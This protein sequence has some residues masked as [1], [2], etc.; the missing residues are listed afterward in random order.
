MCMYFS[1]L[2]L[3]SILQKCSEPAS[4]LLS[5]ALYGL[6][7]R[8]R[9]SA[10]IGLLHAIESI[11]SCRDLRDIKGIFQKNVISTGLDQRLSVLRAELLHHYELKKCTEIIAQSLEVLLVLVGKLPSSEPVPR[12]R[13][14]NFSSK[15][16]ATPTANSVKVRI[17]PSVWRKQYADWSGATS[18][19]LESR[20]DCIQ[21]L[22]CCIPRELH[23]EMRRKVVLEFLALT[24]PHYDGLLHE[25]QESGLRRP[26][27]AGCDASQYLNA[28]LSDCFLVRGQRIQQV[29]PQYAL[30]C[31]KMG[32]IHQEA[33]L[34]TAS[35]KLQMPLDVNIA[36]NL[37]GWLKLCENKSGS[38]PCPLIMSAC[39]IFLKDTP[40]Q[41]TF[42]HLAHV[43]A[44]AD[45]SSMPKEEKLLALEILFKII[46]EL[47]PHSPH[48]GYASKNAVA[49]NRILQSTLDAKQIRRSVSWVAERLQS[50]QPTYIPQQRSMY[51]NRNAIVKLLRALPYPHRIAALCAV[52]QIGELHCMRPEDGALA[53]SVDDPLAC[54]FDFF[55]SAVVAAL[56]EPFADDFSQIPPKYV[57]ELRSSVERQDFSTACGVL[58]IFLEHELRNAAE[59]PGGKSAKEAIEKLKQ[60]YSDQQLQMRIIRYLDLALCSRDGCNLRAVAAHRLRSMCVNDWLIMYHAFQCTRV[61]A[62]AITKPDQRFEVVVEGYRSSLMHSAPKVRVTCLTS[63]T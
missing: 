3:C 11:I 27:P 46:S 32:E 53:N 55:G 16:L 29:I 25:V 40:P 62:S 26:T 57:T 33:W 37:P 5:N 9:L 4:V 39:R 51:A 19:N 15:K 13:V 58:T 63:V 38:H 23:G 43:Y 50:V 12:E 44:I 41:W 18:E 60:R 31:N 28:D 52:P 42:C 47:H 45:C 17:A 1:L 56:F 61:L 2:R 34:E 14:R 7:H 48:L 8:M 10:S 22:A 54:A 36:I 35:Y 6:R 24:V 21:T 49:L 30:V 59:E 20:I